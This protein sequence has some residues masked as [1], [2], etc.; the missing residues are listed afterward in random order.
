MKKFLL[1]LLVL[2]AIAGSAL[3]ATTYRYN[4]NVQTVR[5]DAVGAARVTVYQAGTSTLVSLYSGVSTATTALANP[6]YTDSFGRYYFYAE[7][8]LYDVVISGSN[9]TTYT[10]E[11]VR[12]FSPSA[13]IYNVV[14]Y[15]AIAGDA[16]DDQPGI[17]AAI[18][19]TEDAGGGT[20]RIPSGNWLIASEILV[21]AAYASNAG[22]Y[23]T[24]DGTQATILRAFDDDINVIHWAG[25]F[26][27]IEGIGITGVGY[28]LHLDSDRPGAP[29]GTVV[30]VAG[31]YGRPG[32][33]AAF[34]IETGKK[35]CF[36]NTC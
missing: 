33:L 25:S 16:L 12:V 36:E 29:L 20:V 4:D 22:V 3:G 35:K 8:G 1:F 17:Q 18:D 21:S 11:D 34:D 32:F 10:I 31:R 13:G 28:G 19:A 30:G 24:G 2:V 27:G 7:P 26:G 15:G 5:G 14:D 6:T 23:I 9:I